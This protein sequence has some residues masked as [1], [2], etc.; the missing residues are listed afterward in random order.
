MIKEKINLNNVSKTSIQSKIKANVSVYQAIAIVNGK[1]QS[2][3]SLYFGNSSFKAKTVFAELLI[4]DGERCYKFNASCYGCNAA[5]T[6]IFN[7]CSKALKDECVNTYSKWSIFHTFVKK[8]GV[9]NVSFSY[10]EF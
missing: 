10:F 5:E 3:A 6:A 1:A 2:I 8:L 4:D 9:E 7:V